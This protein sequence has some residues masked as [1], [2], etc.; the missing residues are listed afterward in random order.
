MHLPS[1]LPAT[2]AL[3]TATT[4]ASFTTTCQNCFLRDK[5]GTLVCS[6]LNNSHQFVQT[7]L[8]LTQCF[9]NNNG[10]LVPAKKSA[11]F[12]LPLFFSSSSSLF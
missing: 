1:L 4:S 11:F 7:V 2:L 9:A 5:L 8:G 6:C 12:F 10:V 3:A